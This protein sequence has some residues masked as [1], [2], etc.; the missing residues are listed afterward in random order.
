MTDFEN[1]TV[2][3]AAEQNVMVEPQF[4]AN[5]ELSG[6]SGAET[7]PRYSYT[8]ADGT[9]EYAETTE[10]AISRCHVLAMISKEEATVL[11]EL[12]IIGREKM[13]QNPPLTKSALPKPDKAPAP[14]GPKHA[15]APAAPDEPPIK[16][17]ITQAVVAA[18][19]LVTDLQITE[20]KSTS[21]DYTMAE[22][23]APSPSYTAKFRPERRP[24]KPQLVDSLPNIAPDHIISC[25]TAAASMIIPDTVGM[26]YAAAQ[27]DSGGQ[28]VSNRKSVDD[29]E[30]GPVITAHIG[31]EPA[32]LGLI[33]EAEPSN[34][35]TDSISVL[36]EPVTSTAVEVVAYTATPIELAAYMDN[37]QDDEVE[38]AGIFD[39]FIANLE[40]LAIS[41]LPVAADRNYTQ[42]I[43]MTDEFLGTPYVS[44]QQPLSPITMLVAQELAELKGADRL[45]AIPIIQEIAKVVSSIDRFVT[46]DDQIKTVEVRENQL[47]DLCLRLFN[48]IGIDYDEQ[49][50]EQFIQVISHSTYQPSQT[51]GREVIDLEHDGTHEARNKPYSLSGGLTGAEHRI[52]QLLGGFVLFC[53][54]LLYQ[55]RTQALFN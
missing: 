15:V 2:C 40:D 28:I 32:D 42:P 41:K 49:D 27:A 3:M 19:E 39:D 7:A 38:P 16:P 50:L 4:T 21:S 37:S 1:L 29:I 13:A 36:Y 31:V 48:A 8:R 14:D 24:P 44:E 30:P 34:L 46:M 23:E 25:D 54:S 26:E 17:S 9:I 35:K 52:E 33:A 12:S 18:H 10:E 47:E 55:R 22:Q 6:N 20:P 11:L 5:Q 53:V 51:V 45:L 43:T